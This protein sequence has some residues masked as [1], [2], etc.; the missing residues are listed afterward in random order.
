VAQQKAGA[1]RV[2]TA[3]IG[4][5]LAMV[6]RHKRSTKA[7]RHGGEFPTRHIT[8]RF[9]LYRLGVRDDWGNVSGHVTESLRC[10]WSRQGKGCFVAAWGVGSVLRSTRRISF[11]E[12]MLNSLGACAERVRRWAATAFRRVVVY[13]VRRVS[14]V[15]RLEANWTLR[16][17]ST[18][19]WAIFS[20]R[21]RSKDAQ[22]SR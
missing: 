19:F 14:V 13:G 22:I 10:R 1:R 2:L 12:A 9:I 21:E 7:F 8:V 3:A 6:A 16:Q 18:P 17:P 20:E 4:S 15:R 11:L 5:V